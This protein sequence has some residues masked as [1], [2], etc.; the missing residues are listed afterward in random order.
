MNIKL[1]KNELE[2][3]LSTNNYF[4]RENYSLKPW[5]LC[6]SNIEKINLKIFDKLIAIWRIYIFSET[7]HFHGY[8]LFLQVQIYVRLLTEERIKSINKVQILHPFYH[9]NLSK[10]SHMMKELQ[11]MQIL[12][13]E[14]GKMKE[15]YFADSRIWP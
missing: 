9:F 5:N 1:T 11:Y 4:N 12:I 7:N 2:G 15:P 8:R 3:K 6:I 14:K 13:T 10:T